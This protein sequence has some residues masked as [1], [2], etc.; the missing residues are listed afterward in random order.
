MRLVVFGPTSISISSHGYHRIKGGMLTSACKDSFKGK[1]HNME[2][3]RVFCRYL[4]PKREP[5]QVCLAVEA[6]PFA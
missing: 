4:W 1:M 3:I 2:Y 6:F 5:R